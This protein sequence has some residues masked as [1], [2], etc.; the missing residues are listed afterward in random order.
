MS[1]INFQQICVSRTTNW[2]IEFIDR[3]RLDPDVFAWPFAD[4]S[5]IELSMS[6]YK[7]TGKVETKLSYFFDIPEFLIA[8]REIMDFT[9]NLNPVKTQ[10][11]KVGKMVNRSIEINSKGHEAIGKLGPL[12]DYIEQIMESENPIFKEA[13]SSLNEYLK[14]YISDIEKSNYTDKKE[15]DNMLAALKQSEESMFKEV[16]I[17]EL[18]KVKPNEEKHINPDTGER[19]FSAIS[20]VYQPKMNNPFAVTVSSGWCKPITT[21]TGGT[22]PE[23]GSTKFDKKVAGHM[24]SKDL[25]PLLMQVELFIQAMMSKGQ[26]KYFQTVIDPALY[27][28]ELDKTK[29]RLANT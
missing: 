28:V 9:K 5:K 19:A 1:R 13:G 22:V 16:T 21:G 24:T 17:Y 4:E 26:T 11:D 6:D 10:Y 7:G 23:K 14:E 18:L 27:Q 15:F 2:L 12:K 3:T 29:E 20:F 25:F 8:S